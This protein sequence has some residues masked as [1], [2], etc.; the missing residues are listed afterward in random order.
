MKYRDALRAAIAALA[1]V[2]WIT[3]YDPESGA[4]DHARIDR[5]L[6]D[7]ALASLRAVLDGSET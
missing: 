3:R 5:A 6:V 1:S 7:E 2:E 4:K